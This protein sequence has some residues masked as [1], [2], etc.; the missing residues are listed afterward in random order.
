MGCREAD[1]D[2]E[3]VMNIANVEDVE[4]KE[5]KKVKITIDS[6]AGLSVWPASWVSPG[7]V[8]PS[9]KRVRLE[10][11]NGT[12]IKVHGEKVV[13]FVTEKRD[14]CEMSFVVT[15]VT[16]PLAAVSAIVAAGN[17]VVFKPGEM[18]SYI[19][20]KATGEKI[21]LTCESGTYTMEVEIKGLTFRRQAEAR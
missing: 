18:G 13:N 19:Q 3:L 4:A 2:E 8:R 21:D 9:T 7:E 16:K 6:G 12:P 20:N 10:A 5:A 17:D 1:D 14:V 11:A 15:D